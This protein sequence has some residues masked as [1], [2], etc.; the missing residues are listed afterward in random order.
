M[1]NA[2]RK[3]TEMD[4]LE[5]MVLT[6]FQPSGGFLT[7]EDLRKLLEDVRTALQSGQQDQT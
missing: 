1:R 6:G 3:L 2:V 4:S 7:T 5:D